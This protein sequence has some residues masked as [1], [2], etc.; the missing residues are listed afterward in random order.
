V[1][2]QQILACGPQRDD[3]LHDGV[4]V[5]VLAAAYFDY[6]HGSVLMMRE[7]EEKE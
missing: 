3:I 2:Q 6:D 5:Q 7:R 4:N 1:H